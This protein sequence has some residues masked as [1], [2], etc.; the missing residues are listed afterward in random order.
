MIYFKLI[1]NQELKNLEP[2]SG[3]RKDP[4]KE[5]EDNKEE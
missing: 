1:L 4:P 3:K 5:E 2:R